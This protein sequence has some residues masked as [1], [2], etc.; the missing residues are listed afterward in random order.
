MQRSP[1]FGRYLALVESALLPG[2]GDIQHEAELVHG[3]MPQHSLPNAS[4][5]IASVFASHSVDYLVVGFQ[6]LQPAVQGGHGHSQPLMFRS[7]LSMRI[8]GPV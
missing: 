1:R 7:A 5:Q 3:E 8:V 4:F 6:V 2:S